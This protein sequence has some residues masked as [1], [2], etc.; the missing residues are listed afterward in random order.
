MYE[1]GVS[2]LTE[3]EWAQA[4]QRNEIIGELAKRNVVG[5]LAANEAAAQLGLRVRQVYKLIS[6]YKVGTGLVTDLVCSRSG[7][8]K[9]KSRI[10][11]AVELII[12][13]VIKTRYLSRQKISKAVITREIRMRCR[14]AGY[15]TPSYSTIEARINNL[16]PMIVARK[17]L[18]GNATRR[19]QSAAGR[20]PESAGPLDFVQM[21]HTKMDVIVV[22]EASREPIGRPS[23]TLAIDV[24]TRCIVGM[25]LTLEAPSALS[26]ALCLVHVVTDKSAWL[27]RLELETVMWPMHGKPGK[28]HVDNAPEFKSEALKRGCEQYA[29]ERDYRPKKQP[30]FGGIIERVIGTAMTM[31]HEVPGTTFSNTEQRGTYKSEARAILTLGELEKW[32]ILAIG[33]YHGSVHGSLS[34][35][36][37]AVWHRSVQSWAVTQVAD[38][39]AFLVD[40][41]PVIRRSITRTGFVIDHIA[42]FDDAL[43][44]WIAR[45]DK[46]EKFI[47]RRDPRD[48]SRVWVLDPQTKLYFEIPYRSIF[49]PPVTLWE[50]RVAMEKL[51]SRGREEVNETAIFSLIEQMREITDNAAKERKR[52]RRDRNRRG[53]IGKSDKELELTVPCDEVEE[54]STV[55]PFEVEEWDDLPELAVPDDEDLENCKITPYE[56]EEW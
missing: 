19:L 12:S 26:V 31:A 32:L 33:T 21:D 8:G 43:K 1:Q 6:R 10:Q 45:R 34:E 55:K 44:P 38:K 16:D 37:A 27:E 54:I 9:G 5:A 13:E 20:T 51:R 4:K 22:D 42:Y 40:F 56:V 11:P 50:H 18:G 2:T 29:I 48:L 46:L 23:L 28:I 15:R 30:H 41:L 47:I 36:P 17:R 14:Q 3:S 49:R 35:T 7:G 24:Y 25:L 39:Q 52:A 53:H